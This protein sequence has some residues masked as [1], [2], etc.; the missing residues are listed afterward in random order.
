MRFKM[1]QKINV[2]TQLFQTLIFNSTLKK[3]MEFQKKVFG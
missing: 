2:D 3:R 1:K